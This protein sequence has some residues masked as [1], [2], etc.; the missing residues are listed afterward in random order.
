MIVDTQ[1]VQFDSLSLDCGETLAPVDVAFETWGELN[2]EERRA[3]KLLSMGAGIENER[4]R[5]ALHGLHQKAL[6]TENL[7]DGKTY[8]FSELLYRYV[9]RQ[10]VGRADIPPEEF[11]ESLAPRDRRL[12][13]Y[14]RQRPNEV[15][16]FDEII[17]EVWQ[18][19]G[20]SKQALQAA[21]FRLKTRLQDLGR[22]DLGHIESIRG[23]GYQYVVESE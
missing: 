10:T 20:A 22:P 8:L 14:L 5:G 9:Q 6:I 13:E 11:I 1:F 21:V 19:E 23:K 2:A 18:G 7:E 16:S 4:E 12:F 15:C 17:N 3:L